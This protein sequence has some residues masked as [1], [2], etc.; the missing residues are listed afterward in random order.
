MPTEY[1]T[2][3]GDANTEHGGGW[4][5][6]EEIRHVCRRLDSLAAAQAN[7]RDDRRRATDSAQPN[8]A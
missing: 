1:K 6:L 3:I 5:G 2:N 7:T 4:T 8:G